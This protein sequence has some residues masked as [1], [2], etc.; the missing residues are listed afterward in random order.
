MKDGK[1]ASMLKQTKKRVL[2]V[3]CGSKTKAQMPIP[4]QSDEWDEI[5]FDIDKAVQADIIGTITDMHMIEAGLFDAI[6][7]SHNIEHVY[8]HELP[9]VLSEF[10]RVLKPEIGF[11]IITCP[12]LQSIGSRISD[13]RL[14]EP[15]YLSPAGPIT[16]L[17]VLYGHGAS[18][19]RGNFYMAHKTGFTAKLLLDSMIR[20]GFSASVGIRQT[21][22]YAL[23]AIGFRWKATD[24]EKRNYRNAYL[25]R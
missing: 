4:F 7:S 18:I 8:R 5:R 1:S 9:K 12:D 22:A 2:H 6:Y 21:Q 23:W 10:A 13:G 24:E 14:A 25:P 15:L 16:P 3:G 11:A 20:Y 17:D 19:A